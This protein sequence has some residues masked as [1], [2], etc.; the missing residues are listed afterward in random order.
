[1]ALPF[2]YY[3]TRF[4][5]LISFYSLI[6]K[7]YVFTAKRKLRCT[8]KMIQSLYV[9]FDTSE[10]HD[11]DTDDNF[12]TKF[13]L[14]SALCPLGIQ[15]SQVVDQDES[16]TAAQSYSRQQPQMSLSDI[17]LFFPLF[18]GVSTSQSLKRR[19]MLEMSCSNYL[20][21]RYAEAV[22]ANAL[23]KKNTWAVI[24]KSGWQINNF[25]CEIID[26]PDL[27]PLKSQFEMLSSTVTAPVNKSPALLTFDQA[28][29]DDESQNKNEANVQLCTDK[30]ENFS[31]DSGYPISTTSTSLF[32]SPTL[33]KE[34]VSLASLG[35]ADVVLE[36]LRGLEGF[37][38]DQIVHTEVIPGRPA[39]FGELQ[40]FNADSN[41]KS[42]YLRLVN[43]RMGGRRFYNHQAKAINHILDGKHVVISTA[44]A[45]GKSLIYNLP[46]MSQVL[47]DQRVT[48]LYLFPTKVSYHQDD[49]TT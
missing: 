4:Q 9:S 42:D 46:I 45:S 19:K 34:S 1:M 25:D 11:E 30:L 13:R 7:I 14:L 35:G 22:V 12:L 5:K 16:Q 21:D 28:D 18:S 31:N 39:S 43:E 29:E 37:Y 15:L 41:V 27:A 6:E 3:P 20:R 40:T 8:L 10:S 33:S 26:L 32:D 48:A 44:T 17:E 38:K 47:N 24:R 49:S 36:K 2:E 23:L